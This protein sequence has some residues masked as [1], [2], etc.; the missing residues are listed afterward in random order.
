M[1]LFTIHQSQKRP[2]EKAES[3]THCS[4]GAVPHPSRLAPASQGMDMDDSRWPS[5]REAAR[6]FL[7]SEKIVL[8]VPAYDRFSAMGLVQSIADNIPA[9]LTLPTITDGLHGVEGLFQLG[10]VEPNLETCW[11]PGN[12]LW[13]DFI[14]NCVEL[15]EAGYRG[16]EGCGGPG[17]DE[18]WDEAARR[19]KL[20]NWI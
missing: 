4:F 16:C 7:K 5:L 19:M 13:S 1:C 18:E 8:S 9:R 2:D 6:R 12:N 3:K 11:V 15:L 17:S 10:G 20:S 14:V